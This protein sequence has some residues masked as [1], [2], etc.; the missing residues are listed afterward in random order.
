MTRPRQ[1]VVSWGLIA[2]GFVEGENA[3]QAPD[4]GDKVKNLYFIVL[5]AGSLIAF[6]SMAFIYNIGKK[7]EAELAASVNAS[8]K[9]E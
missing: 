1:A 9:A 3:V 7:E 6:L 4:F 5:A 2:I 8:S